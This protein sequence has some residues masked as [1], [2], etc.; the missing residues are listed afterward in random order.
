MDTIEYE[1]IIDAEW[2]EQ[3]AAAVLAEC[4]R[5]YGATRTQA[6]FLAHS[7]ALAEWRKATAAT[8]AARAAYYAAMARAMVP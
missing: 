5:A 4:D 8:G 6:A 2:R 7:R 3:E 1:A